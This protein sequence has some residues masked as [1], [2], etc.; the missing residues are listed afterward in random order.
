MDE[1]TGRVN[2]NKGDAV[3]NIPVMFPD[4][5]IEQSQ[6]FVHRNPGGVPVLRSCEI[7]Q[8]SRLHDT[9]SFNFAVAIYKYQQ[10]MFL[11]G[12]ANDPVPVSSVQESLSFS[13]T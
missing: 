10:N 3:D 11:S 12:L 7:S 13:T 6:I 2:P 8:R 1:S 4:P 9:K 5:K